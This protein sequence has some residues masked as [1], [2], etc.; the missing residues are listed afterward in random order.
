VILKGCCLEILPQLDIE[1]DLV[2]TDPPYGMNYQ[3]NH[4]MNKHLKIANDHTSDV[5][6]WVI[7][8]SS[9]NVKKAG[10]F[11]CR[12]DFIYDFP[13]PKSLLTWVKNNWGMGDLEHEHARQWE[14]CLFYPY[15]DHKW[16]KGRPQDVIL[17]DR[18]DNN[19]HPTQKP[20]NLIK[21]MLEWC[22]GLVLDPFGGSGTTAVACESLN[23]R[24]ILIEKEQKY[25]DIAIER[26]KNEVQYELF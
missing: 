14:G 21:V 24:W 25:C 4:R 12:W 20:V 22:D 7:D 9:K 5:C 2:L 16:K 23:R 15:N 19:L 10:Y 6:N 26:I 3:S 17:A 1:V 8:W 11:F 13:K 18:T